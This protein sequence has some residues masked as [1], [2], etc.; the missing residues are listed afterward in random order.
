MLE[1]IYFLYCVNICVYNLICILK[2][3]AACVCWMLGDMSPGVG[4]SAAYLYGGK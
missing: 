3:R 4:M 2:L 1:A